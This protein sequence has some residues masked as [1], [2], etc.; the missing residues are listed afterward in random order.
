MFG[1]KFSSALLTSVCEGHLWKL[2]ETV[3]FHLPS[4]FVYGGSGSAALC[5]KCVSFLVEHMI[6]FQLDCAFYLISLFLMP[7]LKKKP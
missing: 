1:L 3:L 2:L 5:V 7:T 6:A 4:A